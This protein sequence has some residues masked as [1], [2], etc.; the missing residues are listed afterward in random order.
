[1]KTC[2]ALVGCLFIV[3]SFYAQTTELKSEQQHESE[4]AVAYNQSKDLAALN[5]L[6]TNTM[7][8]KTTGVNANYLNSH[9]LSDNALY[10][11]VL[12]QHAAQYDLKTQ[13]CIIKKTCL[14]MM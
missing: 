1:M 9:M 6:N 13:M 12:Q 2:I 8:V 3:N 5:N 4:T 14:L 7:A 10:V 11:K